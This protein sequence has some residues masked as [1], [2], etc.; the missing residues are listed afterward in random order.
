MF[1]DAKLW[2]DDV[3]GVLQALNLDR[4]VLCGWS[5]GP[6]VILVGFEPRAG[7]GSEQGCEHLVNRI[8]RRR[9]IG[10]Q[11]EGVAI[12]CRSITVVE[13]DH[14]VVRLNRPLGHDAF[15]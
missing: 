4:P 6:L 3:G 13:T 9:L 12:Q 14:S 2:A 11:H 10:Q 5:Y 8:L 7:A 1:V 15:P